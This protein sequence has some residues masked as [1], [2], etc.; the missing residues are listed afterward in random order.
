MASSETHAA[1]DKQTRLDRE[2]GRVLLR[3]LHKW[4]QAGEVGGRRT[5]E[6]VPL[7]EMETVVIPAGCEAVPPQPSVEDELMETV[8]LSP[9]ADDGGAIEEETVV[10]GGGLGASGRPAPEEESLDE[11][12]ILPPRKE[13]PKRKG[14]R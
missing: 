4:Q 6:T 3:I 8:I 9:R 12:I 13:R 14:S 5:E 2:L 11:T 10:L 1:N 7:E